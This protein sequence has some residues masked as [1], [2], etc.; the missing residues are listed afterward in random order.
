MHEGIC[1]SCKNVR[2]ELGQC[3]A[4]SAPRLQVIPP[5]VADADILHARSAGSSGAMAAAGPL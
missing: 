4:L 1:F 2:T 5:P 3:T